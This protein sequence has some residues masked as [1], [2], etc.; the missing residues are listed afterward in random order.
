MKKTIVFILLLHHIGIFAQKNTLF[1][2]SKVPSIFITIAKDSLNI[3]LATGNEE[4]NH[5]FP[6]TFVFDDGAQKDTVQK[7]GFR[8]RGNTSRYSK[9]KSFKI[10]FNEFE[11]GGSY[12]EVKKLNLNGQHNDPTMI[13]EKLFY[14]IWKK[15][16]NP[17]RRANFV[18]LYVNKEYKGA[19]TNIEE[20]DTDWLKRTYGENKGNL[21]KCTY[22]ADLAYINDDQNSYKKIQNNPTTRAYDLSTNQSADDYSDLVDLCKKIN[23]PVDNQ[24]VTDV[25]KILNVESV[26]KAFA[27]DVALGNWDDYA[28]N[29][30]NYFIYHNQKTK[31]F[32]FITYDTD[33]CVGVNWITG[34]DW[35]TLNCY[36]WLPTGNEKRPLISKLLEVPAYKNKYSDYLNQI[37]KT[38][39][40]PDSIFPRIDVL[41][42][43]I[44]AAALEDTYKKLDWGY[45][46]GS[47]ES[48]FT[49][50]IDGHSPYGVK[51]FFTKRYTS[52]V[53]Q[54]IV[55][56]IDNQ[57]FTNIY[58][59]P[60]PV[61]QLLY[62]DVKNENHIIKGEILDFSGRTIKRFDTNE[63]TLD[64]SGFE[65]GIYVLKIG[66]WIEKFVK[67]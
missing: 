66:N 21:Y 42:N 14:D 64:I 17:E 63:K 40:K 35:A 1:D 2:D 43:V 29:K 23:Q 59:Y 54:V 10:S 65:N 4:S 6:A 28:Y 15:A 3:L 56:T 45:T 60:N 11:K 9:K 55:K 8:L 53:S 61:S 24:F 36:K 22:P 44:E 16:G 30:N 31:K 57:E 12:Q 25:E 50:S 26:I 20:I 32:E 37:T 67:I 41:H 46:N 33:N 7:V 38:I 13:R 49:K 47:W 18:R 62:L 39:T 19:Y 58:F 52:T 34:K 48:G 27:L 5:Y 51:P